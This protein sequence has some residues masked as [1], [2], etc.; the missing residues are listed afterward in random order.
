MLAVGLGPAFHQSGVGIQ[1]ILLHHVSASWVANE[2][3]NIQ[4]GRPQSKLP[5][6]VGEG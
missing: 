2:G 6:P 4:M 5:L 3:D 1:L